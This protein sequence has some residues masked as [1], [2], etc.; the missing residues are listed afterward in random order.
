MMDYLSSP[1]LAISFN[2]HTALE[3]IYM[4]RHVIASISEWPKGFCS[5]NGSHFINNDVEEMLQQ[6]NVS[7][8]TVSISHSTTK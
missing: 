4:L 7:Q 1:I 6:I 3:F 2:D 5:E 8:F